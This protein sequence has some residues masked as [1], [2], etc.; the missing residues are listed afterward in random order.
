MT[1]SEFKAKSTE[2]LKTEDSKLRVE[3]AET[4]CSFIST[5]D[6]YAVKPTHRMKLK[7][8]FNDFLFQPNRYRFNLKTLLDG[9]ALKLK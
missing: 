7:N 9:T 3:L 1:K 8:D 6:L 5:L 4:L 2:L